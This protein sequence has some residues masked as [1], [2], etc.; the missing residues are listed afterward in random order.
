MRKWR[1]CKHEEVD[2]TLEGQLVLQDP[3]Q[4]SLLRGL[5]S[6]PS[7][8]HPFPQV[9]PEF[10]ASPQAHRDLP[11]PPGA[12]VAMFMVSVFPLH[13]RRALWG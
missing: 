11:F 5:P 7:G 1:I 9:F 12:G 3:A 4:K 8:S 13:E 6:F 2:S 10:L